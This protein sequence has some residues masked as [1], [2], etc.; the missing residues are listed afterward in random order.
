MSTSVKEQL[1]TDWQKAQEV[2]SQRASRL[3]EILK[4][5]S[6]EAFTELRGGSSEVRELSRAALANLITYLKTQDLGGEA[7]PAPQDSALANDLILIEAQ[8]RE[9]TVE[10]D[11]PSWRQLLTELFG[12]VRNRRA[13]WMQFLG[14]QVNRYSAKVDSELTQ[15][16]GDR[17]QRVKEQVQKARSRYGA[18]PSASTQASSEAPAT[19][20][21]IEVLED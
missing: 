9:E 19:P 10:K 6:S 17:Y 21:E 18:A 3:R 2:G 7:A 8:A 1:N 20:V 4:S 5:A 12:L 13:D 16:Y 14:Q 11:I 15:E